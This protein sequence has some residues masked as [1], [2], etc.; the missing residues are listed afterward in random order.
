MT[1]GR[2]QSGKVER[3]QTKFSLRAS[4]SSP[5]F[6]TKFRTEVAYGLIIREPS[7]SHRETKDVYTG[8]GASSAEET[9]R[10]ACLGL[11]EGPDKRALRYTVYTVAVKVTGKKGRAILLQAWAGP[12]SFRR[13]R[14]PDFK[15]IGKCRW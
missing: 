9:V 8:T 15:T 4:D 3:K 1:S 2:L 10:R 14:L 5:D 11:S 7:K 13:L 6:R 12:E